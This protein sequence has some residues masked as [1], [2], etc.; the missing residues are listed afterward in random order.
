MS[1]RSDE[2]LNWL[3]DRLDTTVTQLDRASEDASF[4]TYWR[5]QVANQSYILMDAPVSH[6]NSEPFV[7]IAT[8]LA[9]HGLHA[10]RILHQDLSRGFLLLEDLGSVTY[11]D[12]FGT[13]QP[14][15]LYEAAIDALID[16]QC[17]DPRSL[18]KYDHTLLMSEMEL[19]KEWLLTQHLGIVL[20]STALQ[21]WSRTGKLLSDAALEQPQV[22]VHRDYHSRNLMV[23]ERNNPG[24]IDFQDAV[25][26]PITYDL[27]SLLRDC[28]QLWPDDMVESLINRYLQRAEAS[29]PIPLNSDQFR[30]WFD[31][32]GI[33]RHLKASGIFC[34]LHHRD[35]KSGYLNDI[36]AT[37][38][39]IINIAGRYSE[40]N[41]LCELV[42][43]RVMEPMRQSLRSRS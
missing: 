20:D 21:N 2:R 1:Y 31:W 41:W 37:L 30:V 6:E 15:P 33:Q 27:V 4:R 22:F 26:G 16:M 11:S 35:G 23:T 7:R 18:P 38:T 28:Y 34:R 10:P 40:L 14:E 17:I 43:E 5:A 29:L 36:P 25:C 12:G 32:M 13:R 24:I 19:F 3:S 9:A 39:Y 8:L 42:S